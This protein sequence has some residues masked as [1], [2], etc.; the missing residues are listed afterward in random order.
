MKKIENVITLCTDCRHCTGA[1]RSN[2]SKPSFLICEFP[3]KEPFII[4]STD[5]DNIMHY[6]HIIPENCPLETYVESNTNE[7]D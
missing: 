5:T 7:D 4:D 3:D 6:E 1:F 2:N